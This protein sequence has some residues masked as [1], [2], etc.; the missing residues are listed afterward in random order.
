MSDTNITGCIYGFRQ[1]SVPAV[2][3]LRISSSTSTNA[4]KW[5]RVQ[6]ST[7]NPVILQAQVAVATADGGTS[8]TLN[9]STSSNGT[10]TEIFAA[11]VSLAS[12][13]ATTF[14]PA[15]NAVGKRLLTADADLYYK[16]GGT[17]NGAGVSY[18]ILQITGVNTTPA[19]T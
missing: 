2:H 19:A 8:P 4:V 11:P 16:Q 3:T 13:S 17:P 18:L 7:T 9:L 6:A 5:L 12:G 1:G 10:G 14:L 15:S